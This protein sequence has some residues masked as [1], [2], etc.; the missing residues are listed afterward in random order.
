MHSQ[1]SNGAIIPKPTF[2]LL[3]DTIKIIPINQDTNIQMEN[4]Q[5]S[6]IEQSSD[7]ELSQQNISNEGKSCSVI[8]L[9]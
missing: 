3:L 2:T 8:I 1:E 6:V 9:D 5:V 4:E 7:K